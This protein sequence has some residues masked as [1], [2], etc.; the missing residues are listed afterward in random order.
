[1][2]ALAEIAALIGE[3]T[4]AAMLVALLDG[5]AAPPAS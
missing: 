1:M 5:T 2:Y 3:P 4:R